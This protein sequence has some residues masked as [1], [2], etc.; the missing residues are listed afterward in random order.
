MGKYIQPSVYGQLYAFAKE[1]YE[2]AELF[3]T[4]EDVTELVLDLLGRA[5][6]LES[7]E[8]YLMAERKRYKQED[9]QGA[10]AEIDAFLDKMIDLVT[11]AA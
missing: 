6:N 1:R 10:I 3:T 5:H 11:G 4:A 9:D 2:D 8:V 7:I